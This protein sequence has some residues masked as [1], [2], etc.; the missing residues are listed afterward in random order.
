MIGITDLPLELL[1]MIIGFLSQTDHVSVMKTCRCLYNAATFVPF[2]RLYGCIV[3]DRI[4]YA[5]WN[6]DV[7]LRILSTNIMSGIDIEK[8]PLRYRRA[9]LVTG[10]KMRTDPLFIRFPR[11]LHTLSFAVMTKEGRTFTLPDMTCLTSLRQLDICGIFISTIAVFVIPKLPSRLESLRISDNLIPTG[12][13]LDGIKVLDMGLFPNALNNDIIKMFFRG[14]IC[15]VPPLTG[16]STCEE[17]HLSMN[18]WSWNFWDTGLFVKPTKKLILSYFYEQPVNMPWDGF[19]EFIQK[20]G[21]E[22]LQ[23][24]STDFDTMNILPFDFSDCEKFKTI[25]FR[26]CTDNEQITSQFKGVNLV[27]IGL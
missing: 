3:N 8:T 5:T 25:I 19:K 17:L 15:D 4:T 10:A 23:F 16:P 26:Y 20:I 24:N 13:I 18:M 2:E 7:R 27:Y 21:I 1:A 22:T 6:S 12:H 14:S 9:I 11:H